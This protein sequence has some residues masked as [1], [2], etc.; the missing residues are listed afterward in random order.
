M[1]LDGVCPEVLYIGVGCEGGGGVSLVCLEEGVVGE[2]AAVEP[3]V[4]V[5]GE[6][7][8]FVGEYIAEESEDNGWGPVEWVKEV[9]FEVVFG[10][11][12]WVVGVAC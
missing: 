4:P 7:E 12:E 9:D 2:V 11:V 6:E 10:F 1:S 8:F 5:V 3:E